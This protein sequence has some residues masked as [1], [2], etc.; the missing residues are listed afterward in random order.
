IQARAYPNPSVGWQQ[1]PSNNGSTGGLFGVYVDQV[2]RTYGKIKLTTAAAERDLRNAELALKRA[3]SDLATSGRTAY[4]SL[5]VARETGRVTLA[6]A[7]FADEIYRIQAGLTIAGGFSASYEP[8]SLRAQSYTIR[9]AYKQAV[10]NYLY[11][12]KQLVA[13][14]G[15]RQLPL[16]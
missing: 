10:A 4:Y 15:L 7:R 12:W 16:S 13:A 6:L 14:V 11:A 8:A 2:I 5:L 1:D 3:R 9:L